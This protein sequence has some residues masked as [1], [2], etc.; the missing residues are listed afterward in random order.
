MAPAF[1]RSERVVLPDGTR[2]ATIHIEDG[3][4]ARIA[5]YD[6][7]AAG[8]GIDAGALV[9]LPGLV[10]THVHINEPGRADWEGFRT[11]TR[12][13]AAGGVTTLVDM[14]LNSRPATVDEASFEAKLRTADG[15]LHVDVGFWGGIIPGNAASIRPLAER[16]VL[17]FK[18]FLAPS[19]VD[20][21]PHVAEEDLRV[22][23]PILATTGLPLLVHAE[24]PALLRAPDPSANP[25]SYRTWL[26]TRPVESE[27]AAIELLTRL[28]RDSGARIH[29]VHLS[30]AASLDVIRRAHIDGVAISCETCPHYLTFESDRIADGATEFKCAPPLRMLTERE[31]LWRALESGDIEVV[32]TDHSPAPPALKLLEEG[33]VLRAWGGIASLQLGLAAVWTGAMDRGL[34][35]DRLARWMAAAPAKLAGLDRTKGSIAPG[36]DADLVVWDPAAEEI[37]AASKLEHRHHITPYAGMR[38]RGRVRTTMLRGQIVFEDGTFAGRASGKCLLRSAELERTGNQQ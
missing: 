19:G 1:V 3:R 4:I 16:G 32:A 29:V 8:N 20:E 14:P 17:G 35:F 12:A 22:A 15:Q 38:L 6:E 18:S 30:A 34:P 27:V 7:P 13:A 26:E 23:L 2:P 31:G 36:L 33:D 21:F 5:A 11:A 28:A 24:L 37:V 9:V 10:D 25:R